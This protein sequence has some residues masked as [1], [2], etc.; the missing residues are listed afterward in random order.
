MPDYRERFYERYSS[1]VQLRD[2]PV[3][4][5]EAAHWGKPYEKYLAGW[6]P[7]HRDARIVVLAC[8]YG[9]LVHFFT[10]RG[11]TSVTGVDISPQ[12]VALARALHPNIVEADIRHFLE[13]KGNEI[14]LL[15]G[16]DIVEHFKKDETLPFFE[17]AF[18]ALRPGGRLVLQTPNADSPF[19]LHHIYNDFTHETAYQPRLLGQIYGLTGFV[20]AE[21]REQGPVARGLLSTVRAW[22]W[23]ICRVGFRV[24]NMI[25]TGSSGSGIYTRVFIMSAR[26]P[27]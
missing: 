24:F 20:D 3:S 13:G 27:E 9:R 11:Y 18:R 21:A 22:L 15:T 4:P 17:A 19:A 23:A 25:E 2:E 1:I 6:L 14:D 7:Q 16:L 5:E 26:K 12:Q 10:S 8:G